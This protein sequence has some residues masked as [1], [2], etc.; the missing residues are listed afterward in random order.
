MRRLNIGITRGLFF[1]ACALALISARPAAGAAGDTPGR[2]DQPAKTA[3]ATPADS[4]YVSPEPCKTCHQPNYDSW[5]KSAHFRTS[6]DTRGGPSKQGCQGCHGGAAS[7]IADPSDTSKLFKFE[8]A[9]KSEVNAR[10]LTCHASTHSQID[11]SNSFHRQNE[12]SCID[13]HSPHHAKA[14][15]SLL[16]KEQPELCYSCHLQ[17]KSQF[18]MPEHHRVNEGLIQCTDCHNQHGTGGVWESDHLERQVRTA[19]T[20]DF[21]CFKCHKDKQGPFVFPHCSVKI[22]GCSNCHIPHGGANTHML[23]YANVNLL[24]LQCH[25]SAHFGPTTQTG[26]NGKPTG[27]PVMNGPAPNNAI[28]IQ[29]CTICHTQIHGSNFSD[30]YFR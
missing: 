24:C 30:I 3:A 15:E 14:K 23:K 18:N 8:K 12:V 1:F 2:A 21:V 16:I 6:L 17:Q 29:S 26:N 9:S 20:G 27:F 11:S 7:H 13:C 25:T 28:Y 19:D 22:G 4:E 5:E 10:C